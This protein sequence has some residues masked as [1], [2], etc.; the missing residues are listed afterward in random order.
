MLP[1]T[2][3]TMSARVSPDKF[4]L[5]EVRLRPQARAVLS[6]REIQGAID[7]HA[8]GD[9]GLVDEMT[10]EANDRALTKGGGRLV[11]KFVSQSGLCYHLITS[12]DRSFTIIDCL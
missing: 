12:T 7:Q 3:F 5:A 6:L 11:S 9:W 4:L 2:I 10:R 1:N 8:K